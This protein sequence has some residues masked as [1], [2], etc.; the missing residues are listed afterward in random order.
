MSR[1]RMLSVL[2]VL[3]LTVAGPGLAEEGAGKRVLVYGDSNTYGSI[4]T[5]ELP[6]E[7]HAQG[8]PWP[9]VL[10]ELVGEEVEIVAAGLSARTTDVDPAF[11]IAG[12]EL[13]GAKMLPAVLASHMPVDVVVIMLGTNDLQTAHNRSALRIAL[14]AGILVDQVLSAPQVGSVY[15]APQV[16]LIAPPPTQAAA[17][18]PPYGEFFAGSIAKSTRFGE[19]YGAMAEMAGVEFLDA[20]AVVDI[21][22][23][24]GIHFDEA[25]HAALAGAVAEKLGEMLADE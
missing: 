20:G 3:A 1:N 2:A 14:G 6:V 9:Q 11:P 7:R 21:G 19:L 17:E 24:D 13:N 8:V 10:Q 5:L 4:A 25:A 15:P 22:T 16:L 12:I 18:E 23:V